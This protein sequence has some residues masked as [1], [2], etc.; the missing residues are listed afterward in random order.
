MK[1]SA[2][3]AKDNSVG[4]GH[5]GTTQTCATPTVPDTYAG[6]EMHRR[7]RRLRRHR[8][9]RRLCRLRR[10]RRHRKLRS[11]LKGHL[12]LMARLCESLPL[13]HIPRQDADP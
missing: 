12:H 5:V 10:H 13:I 7:H 4:S 1:A 8:R 3:L 11:M 6:N 2:Y 9:D